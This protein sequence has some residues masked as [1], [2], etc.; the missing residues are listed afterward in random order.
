M[1]KMWHSIL[2]VFGLFSVG[3][4]ITINVSQNGGNK[5]SPL[6]YGLMFEV[7]LLLH[8][9]TLSVI[10]KTWC[11]DINHGGDG[12]LYAELVRNRAFQGSTVYPANLAGY[13]SVN[14]AILT[15]QNLT[16]PLSPSM[17]SSLN[18][19]K[20]SNNDRCIGFANEGWWGIEVKPQR[21]AGSF[22]VQ[23]DYQGDFDVS[24]QSKLTQEV[25]ATAKVRSSGNHKDW[26]QY[27]YELVPKKSASNTNNTLTIT[28]D[29]KVC[30]M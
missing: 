28:F 7:I 3:K 9:L 4:A 21:Y 11:Q 22:Y 14:G 13:D 20:G 16:N 5:T 25:F 27:K 17:P 29:S 2:V 24:L 12:G 30:T 10:S 1:G 6:Q 18:V 26:V 15:L 23:G 8:H 19:A